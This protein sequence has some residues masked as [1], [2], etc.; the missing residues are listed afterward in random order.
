[1]TSNLPFSRDPVGLRTLWLA[2]GLLVAL[3]AVSGLARA[4]SCTTQAE[5][6]SAT[7]TTL[8]TAVMNM[9]Q[10]I[11]AGNTAAIQASIAPQV[12]SDA[13]G[14]LSSIAKATPQVRSARFVVRNMYV[15]SA[16]DSPPNSAP[17][18]FFCGSMNQPPRVIFTLAGLRA[19]QYA[20]VMV[21]AN[22]VAQPQQMTMV[23]AQPVAAAAGNAPSQSAA[24][25]KLAG[26]ALKPTAMAGHDGLWYWK[27]ARIYAQNKQDWNAYFYY[28]TAQYLLVPVKF[29]SSS[30]L[31]KLLREEKAV[32]PPGLPGQEPMQLGNGAEKFAITDIHTDASLGGLDLVLRYAT[33]SVQDPVATRRQNIAVMHLMLQEH[34]E[35][36]QAFH[37]LWVY[38][39]APGQ[40]PFGI[41]L[42]INQIP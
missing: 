18:Q 6:S 36:R 24:P 3:A 42:P 33:Q 16:S 8:Q 30:N 31:D 32:T 20:V 37:G 26:F 4:Q 35:L 7:R 13:P 17:A 22:G 15:L 11:A 14:I 9:A 1:M 21:R 25:W 39:V 28:A 5:M 29:V 10:Q 41:E 34:P 40:D 2:T 38:A 27:H 19:G 23:F 12:A